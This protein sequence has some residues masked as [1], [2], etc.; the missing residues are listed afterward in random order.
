METLLS[1]CYRITTEVNDVFGLSSLYIF[2]SSSLIICLTGFQVSA[3]VTN[4]DLVK[5]ILFLVYQ[6]SSVFMVSYHGNVLIDSVRNCF[7]II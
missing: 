2:V 5:Y 1:L 4:K 3:G 7:E 6:C